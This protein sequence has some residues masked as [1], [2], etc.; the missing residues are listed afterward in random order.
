MRSL[1]N[2]LHN[3]L[4]H[5]SETDGPLS[6]TSENYASQSP[7]WD[8]AAETVQRIS[9]EGL[10]A[11]N[12]FNQNN[13]ATIQN[14]V[15][16]QHSAVDKLFSE[17]QLMRQN[18]VQLADL[19]RAENVPGEPLIPQTGRNASLLVFVAYIHAVLPVC[20][21][22]RF[23][24]EWWK[25]LLC[26]ILLT[27]RWKHLT[28]LC[29]RIVI[30]ILSCE[31]WPAIRPSVE[32]IVE[33]PTTSE[34]ASLN[35]HLAK[36]M[37]ASSVGGAEVDL[38]ESEGL[39]ASNSFDS[40]Y[41]AE[42]ASMQGLGTAGVIIAFRRCVIGIYLV[43]Q[44]EIWNRQSRIVD[45][46]SSTLAL[47]TVIHQ[48]TAALHSNTGPGGRSSTS[49]DQTIV[50]SPPDYFL[51]SNSF[52]D[53]IGETNLENV[54]SRFGVTTPK[55]FFTLLGEFSVFAKNRLQIFMLLS[56]FC[57]RQVSQ[58]YYIMD[59]PLYNILLYSVLL[60]THP[61]IVCSSI[62]T[63]ITLI[64]HSSTR[65]KVPGSLESLLD[66]FLQSM[67]WSADSIQALNEI[68]VTGTHSDVSR[69]DLL[70]SEYAKVAFDYSV[71]YF[72]THLYGMFPC[73][74]VRYLRGFMEAKSFA[75]AKSEIRE[76]AK[77]A[78]LGGV[79]STNQFGFQIA[80]DPFKGSR[81]FASADNKD[82]GADFRS[83]ELRILAL[84]S[85]HRLHLNL[86][87]L[88]PDRERTCEHFVNK[89]AADI[90][91]ECL[92][93]RVGEPERNS[94]FPRKSFHNPL[95]VTEHPIWETIGL[96]G[97]MSSLQRQK[98][99][100]D[101]ESKTAID[102]F[103][104][105]NAAGHGSDAEP[106]GSGSG[107]H[108]ATVELDKGADARVVTDVVPGKQHHSLDV[109]LDMN[110]MLRRA[111]VGLQVQESNNLPV[112]RSA[113]ERHSSTEV[114]HAT[115]RP[116]EAVK[117][118]LFLIMNDLNFETALRHTYLQNV[119]KLKKSLL[120]IEME[121][122]DGQTLTSRLKQQQQD[123]TELRL[124]LRRY[125]EELASLRD[126][127]KLFEND[128]NKRYHDSL[129]ERNQLQA[130]LEEFSRSVENAYATIGDLRAEIEKRDDILSEQELQIKSFQLHTDGIKANERI[131]DGLRSHPQSRVDGT[132]TT[133]VF[134]Q[135]DISTDAV[136]IQ[137]N[138][139]TVNSMVTELNFRLEQQR[140]Q[141]AQLQE[142]F[143][144]CNKALAR[145]DIIIKDQACLR[146]LHIWC[147]LIFRR[148][149][150]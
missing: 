43:D 55:G 124:S 45:E 62:N 16:S 77:D 21:P 119:R 4:N 48:S 70:L 116:L 35:A 69:T 36:L 1:L 107:K 37:V 53:T 99:E 50:R 97:G 115:A 8:S 10:E 134:G 98:R 120:A 13:Q 96:S 84:L 108:L 125:S 87:L 74:T 24:T 32:K 110:R 92:D 133:E 135:T 82:A 52:W 118:Q 64:P 147:H 20:D 63:I 5:A 47:R 136:E 117:L 80:D 86:V 27:S 23:I 144:E 66:V 100:H 68:A 142:R 38:A 85:Q 105:A 111:I 114:T 81:P 51:A 89:E 129:T 59:T 143:A 2:R 58:I 141:Y 41:S 6:D 137:L 75:F 83:I 140:S 78:V 34:A 60:D 12:N 26:P 11:I 104:A 127:Q 17:L 73:A 61:A 79:T 39:V 145:Q 138:T 112:D 139:D 149:K 146:L 91:M 95:D 44:F 56:N 131:F 30:E 22:A 65:F 150:R 42:L 93:L 121:R 46:S 109:V 14:G 40:L 101:K 57:R 49:V 102:G 94:K 28:N 3:D 130:Q 54:I 123:I 72:F 19:S 67:F 90:V 33:K 132:N 88:D 148:K 15:V 126:S 25:S 29:S 7:P 31:H 9:D 128:W 18:N 103:D 106:T 76:R 122:A 71:E 113:A